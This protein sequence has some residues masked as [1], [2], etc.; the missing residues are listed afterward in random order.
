MAEYPMRIVEGNYMVYDFDP[1]T[2]DELILVLNRLDLIEAMR[3][4]DDQ[5]PEERRKEWQ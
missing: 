2:V 3:D 5:T 1:Y 4:F